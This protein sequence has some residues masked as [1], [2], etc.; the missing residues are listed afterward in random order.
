MSKHYLPNTSQQRQ[1][2]LQ[3][4]GVGA[5]ED[6][7]GYIPEKLRFQGLL[8]LP[9]PL[10]EP[11]LVAHMEKLA[12]KNNVEAVSFLGGGIYDHYVPAAIDH[13][14]RRSEFYTAYTPYQPEV[15]QGTLQ[16]IFEYQS[17]ICQLTG[18][19][20]ANASLYDG[21]TAV[22][23]AALLALNATKGR[24]L[25]VAGSMHPWYRKVLATYVE[26][27]EAEIEELPL[28]GGKLSPDAIADRLGNDVAA[29]IVQSP[30]FFGIIEDLPAL[31]RLMAAEKGL[32]V[33]STD[34]ISLGLLEAPGSLGADVI[35]GEGQ[36]LGISQSY[37]GPLLGF[38]GVS[39]KLVRK[40]P[41]RVVG[42]TVDAKGRRGFVLTLQTREQHIRR[43]KATSNICSNQALCALAASVYM[44]L[45]GP[46][47]IREVAAQSL[48]NAAFAREQ[49][50]AVP[51]VEL[52]FAGPF[53]KEFALKLPK[54]AAE[55]IAA[56]ADKGYYVG[57]D[58]GRFFPA[59]DDHLLMAVTEKRS[60]SEILGCAA[61]LREVL[62]K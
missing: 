28:E 52:A 38:M 16:A 35:T 10:A 21:G 55:V 19:A 59:M 48:V 29:L 2:M 7:F 43:E 31:G 32:F 1:Q 61:A 42:Q 49:M 15:S 23:E 39:E 17:M 8:N 41:G 40:I 27:Y 37:G 30:N 46:A 50:T 58:L 62:A 20:A 9:E 47:G 54:P 33:V 11:H 5:V 60:K 45:M 3:A 57:I 51:G 53:F 26:D 56:M 14:L 25:L 12:G 34:P 44:S 6:L 4:I 18:A 13:I 22:A 24:R 36:S